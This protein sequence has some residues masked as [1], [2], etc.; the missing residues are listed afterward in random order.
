MWKKIAITH[1][2]ADFDALASA[3]AA[4]RLFGCDCIA[5]STDTEQNVKSYL[6]TLRNSPVVRFKPQDIED[7]HRLDH[8]VITDCKQKKRLGALS[9]I[10]DKADRVTIYD[11][12]P[13]YAKDIDTPD[14]HISTFGACTTAL[15]EQLI[16]SDIEITSDEATLYLMGIYEDTGFMTFSTTTPNDV[17]AVADLIELGGDTRTVNDYVK[18]EFSREQVFILNE[19]LMNLSLVVVG[20]VTV[21]YS[22][23]SVDEYVED[24]AYLAHRMMDVE[25]LP[26]LLL[27]VRTGPRI[28][29]IGRSKDPGVDVSKVVARFGGGGHPSAASANIKDMELYEAIDHLKVAIREHI[30]PVRF[31]GEIMSTS[32]RCL[33]PSATFED[34]LEFTLKH[35]LN[36]IPVVENNSTIGIVTRKDILQGLKHGLKAEPVSTLMRTEVVKVAPD[37]PFQEAESIMVLSGQK[38]LPVER[39][40]RLIGVVTRTDLLRL[41]HEERVDMT[42]YE[43]GAKTRMGLSR[44]RNVTDLLQSVMDGDIYSHLLEIGGLA[45]DAGLAAYLVGGSVRDMLMGSASSDLDVVVEGDA[46]QVAMS[47]AGKCGGKISVHEKYKTATVTRPDGLKIDFAAAR[48][49]FYS[50]PAAVP[51]VEASSLRSDLNRRDFTIN[52]MAVRIDCNDFGQLLDYF[53]GQRDL[54]DRKIRV[55]HSLSFI[56]DPSRAFRALR[57]A[58]RFDFALGANTEKLIKDA[59]RLGVFSRIAG[60]RLFLEIKYILIEKEYIKALMLLKRYNLFRFIDEKLALTD[61][62][63]EQFRRLDAIWEKY[64]TKLDHKARLWHI[65]LALL[66]SDLTFGEYKMFLE[67]LQIEESLSLRLLNIHSKAKLALR[68]FRRNADNKPSEIYTFLTPLTDEELLMFSVLLGEKYDHMVL[69]YLD[70]YRNIKPHLAGDDLKKMG[71]PQ[72]PLIGEILNELLMGRLDGRYA[73]RGQEEVYVRDYIKKLN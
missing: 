9:V 20:G 36:S 21:A 45:A 4:H 61:S 43:K 57:F 2:K 19:L 28:V 23:A 12:H 27:M 47:Y 35:N 25:G 51:A 44:V 5:I 24:L 48:T 60:G 68:T 66:M 41:M 30:R 32:P 73:T 22:Y 13:T 31:V 42:E 1:V 10:M 17:R 58:A 40:G 64:E 33:P 71:V 14:E 56:D 49:E 65:R 29:L 55:L 62:R 34:A 3:W 67:R 8:L 72:S 70:I 53:G 52:A 11:H 18:K 15:V 59:E 38:L 6:D 50:N 16:E 63:M 7:I 37:T 54:L 69:N 39:G 46:I 26:V